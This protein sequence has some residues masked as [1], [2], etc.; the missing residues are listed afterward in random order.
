[1]P[2]SLGFV[3]TFPSKIK[4]KLFHLTSLTTKKETQCLVGFFKLLHSTSTAGNTPPAHLLGAMESFLLF[5]ELRLEK[6]LCSNS[7]LWCKQF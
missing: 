7:T 6:V 1:M 2:G 4:D 3:K 5:V